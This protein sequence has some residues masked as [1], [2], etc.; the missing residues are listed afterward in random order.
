M[1][2][3]SNQ[4]IRNN[5]KKQ[6]PDYWTSVEASDFCDKMDTVSEY[7]ESFCEHYQMF[8]DLLK[9][10]LELYEKEEDSIIAVLEKYKGGSA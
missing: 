3:R 2:N 7:F 10:V 6:I 9:R 1:K 4:I 8:I 5:Q